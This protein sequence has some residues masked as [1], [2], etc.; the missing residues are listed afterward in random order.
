MKSV[1]ACLSMLW[2]LTPYADWPV[3]PFGFDDIARWD[4][5]RAVVAEEACTAL[6]GPANAECREYISAINLLCRPEPADADPL[7]E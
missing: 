1:E 3:T 4:V 2:A 6:A 7:K 5:P